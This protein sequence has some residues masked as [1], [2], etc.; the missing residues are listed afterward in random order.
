MKPI[1]LLLS[2]ALLCLSFQ[3]Y[4]SQCLEGKKTI[5]E[6]I[7]EDGTYSDFKLPKIIKN[8]QACLLRPNE[9]TKLQSTSDFFDL[10]RKQMTVDHKRKIT[11]NELPNLLVTLGHNYNV[12]L[13]K[14]CD[15]G[16][17]PHH[18]CQNSSDIFLGFVAESRR[19]PGK[20]SNVTFS[21]NQYIANVEN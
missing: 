3:V 1:I 11:F 2:T 18:G 6:W 12:Y 20:K 21:M 19:N 17:K 9:G 16:P 8:S 10:L 7:K 15:L 4:G 13:I 5:T 14:P